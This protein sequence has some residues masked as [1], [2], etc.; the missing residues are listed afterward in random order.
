VKHNS[1]FALY[2]VALLGDVFA[3]SGG[4]F[5]KQGGFNIGKALAIVGA[6]M[7]AVTV[8]DYAATMG[9]D[10]AFVVY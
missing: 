1:R 3:K 4:E 6:E 10:L 9:V 7:N 5:L 8:G 2:V